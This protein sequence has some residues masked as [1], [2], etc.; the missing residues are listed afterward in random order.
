[1][2]ARWATT[3]AGYNQK[4][5]QTWSSFFSTAAEAAAT[6]TGLIFVAV[7]NNLSL[8]LAKPKLA[9]RALEPLILLMTILLSSLGCLVPD[10]PTAWLGAELLGLGGLVCL[11]VL[12]LDRQMLA[13]TEARHKRSYRHNV[14]FSQIALL[15]YVLAGGLLLWTGAGLPWV[16][17]GIVLTFVKATTDAWIILVEIKR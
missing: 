17:A 3:F 7:S 1:M 8:I 9:N 10:H 15:P 16:C 4:R 6:L 11:I 12:R 14:L 13:Q 5:M 2:T